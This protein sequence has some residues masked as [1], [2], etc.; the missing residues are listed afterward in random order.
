M[1]KTLRTIVK[2]DRE[3]LDLPKGVQDIIPVRTIYEDGIF[4]TGKNKFSKTYQFDDINYYVASKEDKEAMFLEY[5]ELLNALDSSATTK[6]TINNR[7][8][9]VDKA[10]TLRVEPEYD[11]AG[12]FCGA[13]GAVRKLK[14]CMVIDKEGKTV[15]ETDQC[16]GVESTGKEGVFSFRERG[17]EAIRLIDV[18]SGKSLLPEETYDMARYSEGMWLLRDLDLACFFAG[19]DLRILKTF[20]PKPA[21]DAQAFSDDLAQVSAEDGSW[22]YI[23]TSGNWQI[24]PFPEGWGTDFQEGKA[25]I[26]REEGTLLIDRRGKEIKRFPKSGDS[27]YYG[28]G[29]DLEGADMESLVFSHG[30]IPVLAGKKFGFADEK[31]EWKVAPAFDAVSNFSEGRA[32][33]C[34]GGNWG[35]IGKGE[36]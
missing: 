1:I 20:K 3:G 29:E 4:Q 22:G 5:S 11:E 10:G 2:Q 33:V 6:L 9:N 14:S 28:M 15:Y 13:Y 30:R 8:L 12:S 31:G 36:K 34:I 7:R 35:I 32:A 21:D 27:L 17:T 19:E 25:L 24:G 16:S 23:N 26:M 18:R